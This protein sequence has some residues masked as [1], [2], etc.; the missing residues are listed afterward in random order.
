[1]KKLSFLA[2]TTISL[3]AL[4]SSC[5]SSNPKAS[6]GL[7][8]SSNSKWQDVT[9]T[10]GKT[11]S[12]CAETPAN[13]T[14]KDNVSEL[15]WSKKLRD[16]KNWQDAESACAALTHNGQKAGSWRLPKEEELV[17]AYTHQIND[18]ASDNWISVHEMNDSP[19]WS[20]SSYWTGSDNAWFVNLAFGYTNYYG[21][22]NLNAVV[23]VQ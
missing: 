7:Q 11:A 6:S 16:R 20:A 17:A 13:C 12:T 22:T 18:A 4:V 14:M 1:M 9:T 10:D 15:K 2:A 21:K 23:C 8:A 19:Y 5:G 3:A